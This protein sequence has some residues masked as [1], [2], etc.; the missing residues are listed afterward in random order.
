M[1]AQFNGS[2]PWAG[3]IQS[4][5]TLV[6]TPALSPKEMEKLSIASPNFIIP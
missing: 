2:A 4:D 5:S 3:T 1:G 6:P